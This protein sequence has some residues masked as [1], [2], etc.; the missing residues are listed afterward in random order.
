[1]A[2]KNKSSQTQKEVTNKQISKETKPA[3]QVAAAVVA[4]PVEYKSIWA[5]GWSI[6][7]F[8]LQALIVAALAFIFYIN[9]SLNEFAHDD[10]IVIVKNEYVQEGFAGIPMILSR[11]AYDSYYRQLNTGNQL[12]GGRYRPLS[13]VTFAIEQQ[14]FGAVP[15]EKIDSFLH[16][17]MAYGVRSPQEQA[18]VH[19]MQMRHVFNVLWYM[20]LVVVILYFLRYIIFPNDP[21]VALLAAVFFTIHPIHTE[22]VANVKSRDEIMSLLFMCLTFI[23]AFKYEERKKLGLLALGLLSFFLA[24]M[25]KEYA[26]TLVFLLPFS[27]YLFKNY[28]IKKSLIACLPYLIV[29]GVY[30]WIRIKI[31]IITALGED[32][33]SM[34]FDEILN[35]IRHTSGNSEKEI[36]NNPYYYATHTEKL[37]TEIVSS[38]RYIKFLLW[39]YPLSADYSYNTIPYTDF[40]NFMVYVSMAVHIA[41]AGLV[42]FFGFIKKNYKILS[43]ALAFYLLHLLLVNNL[44]FDIGATLGERLIFHSS[45]GFSILAA[46][47]LFQGAQKINPADLRLKALGAFAIVITIVSAVIAIPRNA[48]WKNDGTLFAADLK[49][50]PNSILVLAN[51]AAAEVSRVDYEK[52]SAKRTADLHEAIGLLDKAINLHRNTFVAGF[53]NRG[54][55]WYKLGDIDKAK[56]NMDSVRALYPNYPTLKG[57]YA[58]ISDYYMRNGWDKYGR[59][60]KYTEAIAEFYKGLSVDS[61]NAQLWYNLGGAYYSNHQLPEAIGAWQRSLKLKPDNVQAQQGLQAAMGMMATL[62]QQPAAKR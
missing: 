60:G 6:Y 1:M 29:I 9:S 61:T 26:I 28:P 37:A 15:P 54:I 32:A 55:A 24:F 57:M 2:K 33:A 4:P 58:L 10:G 16:R 30:L 31:A 12:T 20:L 8:K 40:G 38:L 49:V 18:L 52:D 25:S 44:V 45:L 51:V 17:T 46:W 19:Q 5:G 56:A 36:L 42:V 39:P 11:D 23:F 43:F 27:F 62:Q 53:L 14:F 50:T 3:P 48:E 35:A 21:L 22:V 34:S 41:L 59:Y 13:I 7:E 47:L